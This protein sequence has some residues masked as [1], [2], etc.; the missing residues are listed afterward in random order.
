MLVC[1]IHPSREW[2]LMTRARLASSKRTQQLETAC[3]SHTSLAASATPSPLRRA[4]IQ[5]RPL[6]W[7]AC[8]AKED[9]HPHPSGMQ[10]PRCR[11]ASADVDRYWTQPSRAG[12]VTDRISLVCEICPPTVSLITTSCAPIMLV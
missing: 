3:L 4:A 2:A 5:E 6:P 1:A 12:S 8:Q 11:S 10:Q 9:T 7:S